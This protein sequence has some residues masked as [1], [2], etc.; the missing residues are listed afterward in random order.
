MSFGYECTPVRRR[1]TAKHGV[2]LTASAL[3]P[4]PPPHARAHRYG[5]V[6]RPRSAHCCRCSLL[7]SPTTHKKREG[8][9]KFTD[10][11]TVLEG[12]ANEKRCGGKGEKR[13]GAE[14]LFVFFVC[15]MSA[16]W[17]CVCERK[18]EMGVERDCGKGV[19][20]ALCLGLV[21]AC[22]MYVVVV[23]RE[24]RRRREPV[25]ESERETKSCCKRT[26]GGGDGRDGAAVYSR[27]FWLPAARGSPPLRCVGA[28]WRK[29]AR[30]A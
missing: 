6:W 3:A 9:G 14:R 22:A 10:L 19:R 2:F 16:W 23:Q 25:D 24:K 5:G 27:P 17:I 13:R 8:G 29:Q 11:G 15:M 7:Q 21:V 28:R 18:V 20:F 30:A 1:H 4:P 26:R 12:G